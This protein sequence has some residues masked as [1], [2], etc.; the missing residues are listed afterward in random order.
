MYTQRTCFIALTAACLLGGPAAARAEQT[1]AA[2]AKPLKVFIL[3]GQSNMQGHAHV[4]TIDWLGQDKTHGKLVAKLKNSDGKPVEREDVWIYYNRDGKTPKKGNLTLGYGVSNDHIGP[5]A[6]FGAVM[7]DHFDNQVLLIK[8]AWGGQS[9]AVD[10]RPPSAGDVPLATYPEAMRD[11]MDA[12][13]KA[14]KLSPGHKYREMIAEVQKVLGDVKAQFPA[15]ANQGVELAGFVWFQ[16]WNDMISKE[17][18]AEY[19]KNMASFINDVRKDLKAPKLPVVVAVMGV[20]GKEAGANV[21]TFRKA[22]TAGCNRPEFA[23]NVIAL[24]TD[25]YWDEEAAKF[26]KE[27]WI[28]RKW[29]N[30]EARLKWDTMGSQPPYH[31]LGSAKVLSLIGFGC[32]ESMK[33]LL[34]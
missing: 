30:E 20:D 11:K 24:P 9:L 8:T 25:V 29:P 18:T 27:N 2:A 10:F 23:G 21:L 16:G 26:L 22:Q 31:Y 12:S 3:A 32:A 1:G 4:R 13:I 17:F 5:E 7:G 19:E 34:K 14:G 6:M 33:T 28:Q 15:Y